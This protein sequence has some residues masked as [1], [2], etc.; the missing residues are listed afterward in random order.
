MAWNAERGWPVWRWAPTRA[1]GAAMIVGGFGAMLYCTGLF[2]RIGRGTPIPAAP[3]ENLVA[4]GLYRDSRD[5]I[6]VD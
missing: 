6:R 3:P 2:A 1:L 4:R 5:P